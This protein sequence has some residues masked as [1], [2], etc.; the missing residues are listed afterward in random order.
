[1]FLIGLVVFT[2]QLALIVAL[3]VQRTGRRRVEQILIANDTALR[4]S[5][6]QNRDLAGRLITAQEAERTRIARDL[7]DGV[8]QELASV[9]VD[10][11]YLRQKGGHVQSLEVQETLVCLQSRLEGTAETLR[12]LSHGLH[13]S[14]LQHIGLVAALQSHCAEVERQHHI[15]VTFFADD[16][17]EPASWPPA[18]ALFR[19]AQEA[20]RNAARHARARHATVSLA[21]SNGHL[22]LTV[23]DDGEGFDALAARQ[24]G[25][26]GLASI[27]E[28]ARLVQGQA[29]I[30]SQPGQGTTVDVR[31]AL[32]VLDYSHG[33][34]PEG[35]GLSSPP[36][37]TCPTITTEEP[38]CAVQP[39]CSLTITSSSP[40]ALS[41]S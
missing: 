17:V 13:P 26:L 9:S 19:I 31:V 16:E 14:V 20:L 38:A 4:T 29:T 23:A 3:L 28:R 24:N 25:G 5:Y 7:H 30:R 8:C 33:L 18:L 1:M 40:T 37:Q 22:T 36:W 11:S 27:E 32:G 2:I 39:S 41:E 34:E 12:L 15:H 21:R 10:V 6:E 35:E